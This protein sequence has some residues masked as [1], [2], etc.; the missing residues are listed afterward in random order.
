M[1]YPL[2]TFRQTLDNVRHGRDWLR[3]FSSGYLWL[4]VSALWMLF[5]FSAW[6]F[7]QSSEIGFSFWALSYGEFLSFNNFSS[8]LPLSVEVSR[9]NWFPIDPSLGHGNSG[10]EFFPYLTLW[11]HGL[12]ISIFG[13][14][15]SQV[16]GATFLPVCS[17]I[18]MVLIFHQYLFW[19][20]SIALA[21]LG[22]TGFQ[23]SAFR[24]FL[25]NFLVG[26]GW[27]NQAV[28]NPPVAAG[29]PFP[30][31]SLLFF[32]IMFYLSIRRSYMSFR[33]ATF[34]SIAWA[35]Q[36]QVHILNVIFGL[37]FWFVLLAVNLWRLNQGRWTRVQTQQYLVQVF[38]AFAVC[39]PMM[40]SFI[41]QDNQVIGWS[42]LGGHMVGPNS[43]NW[44]F[45]FAYC[46]MP[47]GVLAIVYRV[48]RIDPYEI[49]VKFLPIWVMM[50]V[51]IAM[52]IAWEIFNIGITSDLAR[53]RLGLPF[54]HILYF[55]PVIYF[56]CR[57]SMDYQRGSEGSIV[58]RRVRSSLSYFFRNG[59]YFYLFLFVLLL[60]VHITASSE[61]AEN[62][63]SSVGQAATEEGQLVFNLLSQDSEAGDVLVG[64]NPSSN[65][66][67]PING[68]Y[69][70]LWVNRFS[71]VHVGID[72]AIERF[73]TYGRIIGW[74]D[75]QFLTFMLP[76]KNPLHLSN[77][78]YDYSSTEP[79]G[80]LG[81][82]LVFHKQPLNSAMRQDLILR[83]RQIYDSID[84]ASMV[85][86]YKIRR[87]VLRDKPEFSF[88]TPINQV[89][90]YWILTDL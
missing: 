87:I 58:S 55:V 44:F 63:F 78:T 53:M 48:F 83:L 1:N 88:K 40:V 80:G 42:Q 46:A 31:I 17:F 19:R 76:Q 82:F 26:E 62:Y 68:R 51:E 38:I 85:K 89:A 22:I 34:L 65:I 72:E 50:G 73:A 69:G 90:G 18:V 84:V 70:S 67:V 21:S 23:S 8:W 10:L 16:V 27:T 45:L 2:R 77:Q 61:R 28:I 24:D 5:L 36:S 3:Y 32:L 9:G 79:I 35:L 20:W 59:S 14:V 37:P 57:S 81:F 54:L 4:V 75:R 30:A 66:A 7:R 41:T 74:T 29:F 11:C 86:K 33:R 25:F 12:L 64:P 71:D 49:G 60:T 39:I 43:V 47:L 6:D 13:I 56:L 52:T 15:G